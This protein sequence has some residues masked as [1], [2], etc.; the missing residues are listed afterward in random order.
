MTA[1]EDRKYTKEHEWVR[2]NGA[3]ADIGITA[4]AQDQLGEIVFIEL[5][6]VGAV[7]ETGKTFCVVESTK[8]ASDVYAP[9]SGTVVA[10]NTTLGSDPSL[11]NRDP[12]EAGWLIRITEFQASELDAL[13][14]AADY[15]A[16]IK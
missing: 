15:E 4:F 11:V 2:P 3:E 10:V 9:I 12:Y 6:K 13:M 16:L 14:T 8:A 7:V 1:P 5:P